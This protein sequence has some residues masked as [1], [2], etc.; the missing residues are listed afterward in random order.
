[1][2]KIFNLDYSFQFGAI[3]I[4]GKKDIYF[5]EYMQEACGDG[6]LPFMVFYS[7]K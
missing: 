5:Y 7:G 1:M 6:L 3:F 4:R 2:R